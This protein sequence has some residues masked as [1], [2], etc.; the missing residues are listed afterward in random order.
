MAAYNKRHYPL[1]FDV[2]LALYLKQSKCRAVSE[3]LANSTNHPFT[4]KDDASNAVRLSQVG[5]LI[6]DTLINEEIAAARLN[7]NAALSEAFTKYL[8]RKSTTIYSLG[9]NACQAK[10]ATVPEE[11]SEEEKDNDAPKLNDNIFDMPAAL[12]EY[13]TL[14]AKAVKEGKNRS[15]FQVVDST[16][17]LTNKEVIKLLDYNFAM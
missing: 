11:D 12:E 13:I 5:E 3:L 6:T 16:A 7:R 8:A 15:Y 4:N 2:V 1:I 17:G 10:L 14:A 9:D